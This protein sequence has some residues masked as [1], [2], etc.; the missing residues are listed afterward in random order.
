MNL[1]AVNEKVQSSEYDSDS[2]DLSD[3]EAFTEEYD[4][5]GTTASQ[6]HNKVLGFLFSKYKTR[7]GCSIR[8]SSKV[9]L[10]M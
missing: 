2:F 1:R 8:T 9:L 6:V 3:S 4:G 5:E 7:S 10:W